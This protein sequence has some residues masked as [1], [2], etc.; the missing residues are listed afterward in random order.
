MQGVEVYT[1]SGDLAGSG[2]GIFARI[3]INAFPLLPV[4]DDVRL[5]DHAVKENFMKK[6]F[7]YAARTKETS[8]LQILKLKV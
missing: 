8:P 3:F 7:E 5:R 6:I 4:E 1:P 2:A